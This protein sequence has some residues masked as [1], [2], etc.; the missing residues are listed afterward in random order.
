M[1]ADQLFTKLYTILVFRTLHIVTVAL[2]I[3]TV[4]LH[5]VTITLHIVTVAL[6]IVTLCDLQGH[7]TMRI[8]SALAAID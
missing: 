2:H 7:R 1:T 8:R 3:V 4:T 6:H 5:I